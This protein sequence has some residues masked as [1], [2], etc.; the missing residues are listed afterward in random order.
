VLSTHPETLARHGFT[1][2][3]YL[4]TGHAGGG[5]DWEQPPPA[6]GRRSIL[7]RA[8]V[9]ELVDAG[10]EIG[11]HTRTHPDLRQLHP[12]AVA[13]EITGSREDIEER[14][15]RPVETFAFPGGY[16]SDAAVAVVARGFTAGCTT[17]LRRATGDDPLHSL[18]RADM[19]YLRDPERLRRLA[20][21]HLDAFLS[22]RRLGRGVR[23]ALG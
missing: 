3:I 6:L 13:Q 18:P 8:Q 17:V 23:A 22:F 15:S 7:D 10:W 1:A 12:E 21:G 5:H 9:G 11:A 16:I 4:I 14:L 20:L 19:Y 2:S